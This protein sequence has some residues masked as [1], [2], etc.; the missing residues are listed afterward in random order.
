[1]NRPEKM[2]SEIRIGWGLL[3]FGVVLVVVGVVYRQ[4]MPDAA[5]L[6]RLVMTFGIF[7]GGWGLLSLNKNILAFRDPKAAR[8][9]AIEA[10]DERSLSIRHRAGYEGFVFAM[11]A[12]AVGLLVYSVLTQDQKGF[13]GL[14]WYLAFMVVGPG[15]FY[16]IRLLRIHQ[17][18]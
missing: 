4:V 18:Y 6:G 12:S 8:R 7:F 15:I 11:V 16:V 9:L 3:L 5:L 2:P 14:W 13:D 1:M 17:K 10:Q